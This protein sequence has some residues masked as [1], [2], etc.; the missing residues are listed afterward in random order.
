MR[1]RGLTALLLSTTVF[2]GG[3]AFAQATESS[4]SSDEIVVTAQKRSESIQDVPISIQALPTEKLDELNVASFTDFAALLPSVSFQN[5]T[6]N[7]G[8]NIYIRGV[9]SGGDGNHSGPL[10][11]V[12]VYLDEQP[13]TT[14][15]GP[16]DVNIYDIARI[17]SLAGP[18]GTLYGASS[19]AGT[20]RI[21]TNKPDT[22]SF[23]GRW[24]VE[25][26]QVSEGGTGGKVQGM[27]NI[28][29][30]S[31]AALRIV[32][33]GKHDA[34]F[35]DNVAGTRSFLGG[36][37]VNNARFVED[38]FNAS[39]LYGGR[40]ALKVDLDDNWTATASLIGQQQRSSGISA[41]DESVG[42][43]KVQHFYPDS[44]SDR[45]YQ[46]ALTIEG[47][48]ANFDVT[49][50]GAYLERT[51]H[52]V[53]DYTDYAEAYDRM[54]ASYGGVA[55][56]FY[57]QDALGNTI[58]PRQYII[59]NSDFTKES[60]ELRLAS[61]A[62][63]RLRFVAGAF[64]QKQVHDIF[65]N[66]VVP[67][68]AANLSVNGAPET[69]WLTK[70][71]RVDEDKA[72]FGEATFD[73]TDT[74]SLT[75]GLRAFEYDNSL[76]GFFGFGRD[77]AGP[78]FNAAGSSRT[79][80]AGCYTTTGQVLR[81]NPGGTLLP[82]AI[83]GSPCTNLATFVNGGLVP[84]ATSGD[85]TTYRFNVTYQPTQDLLFYATASSGF[86]PG[87]INRRATIDPYASDELKN[88]EVG[89]KTTWFDRS[90]RWN[91][92]VYEQKW[93][94]FQFAFLG[95]NSF[96]Q[97][98]NGPDAT[99]RGVETDLFWTPLDGLEINASGSYTDA[100]TDNNLC[101]SADP[102]FLCTNDPD[103][104]VSA[105]SGTRLP[106]TP[107]VKLSLSGRYE[108]NVGGLQP[109]AQVLVSYRDSAST[110]LRTAIR[111]SGTLNIINP[112]ALQGRLP[113]ATVVNLAFGTS[114]ND[115]VAELFVS[116]LFDERA[117]LTRYSQCGFCGQ[118]PYAVIETPRTIGVRLG[119]KF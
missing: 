115:M 21:I 26:N 109:Y 83:A 28:P 107:K 75:A 1:G 42:D 66:Y 68:L 71:Q 2:G 45:F 76:I 13:V 47:T 94:S 111:E 57:F 97:I 54:Y 35:I 25:A 86:R 108:W 37:T 69:L 48:L 50:A 62:D 24:D 88:L 106:I 91:G 20:I 104:L 102:T 84:K 72:I 114:W 29:V 93:E 16:I 101:L 43:L 61:P 19:E 32:G 110:D 53:N 39:D 67:G 98:Q 85:G 3:Q 80:V 56:Y 82:A 117:Q 63:W 60:H 81:D 116:N 23:Y 118:R 87:G 89:W 105:P 77:A 10:P 46:A 79:G 51:V 8:T 18:Q 36:V 92:A 34:G 40:A 6:S 65:Q 30:T 64:Y 38:D 33:W 52:T 27:V 4:S 7:G 90:L 100:K 15:A 44:A 96:T 74:I 95:Q 58:D 5:G 31:N 103:N 113:S 73:L 119:S 70:Q 12:G 78:P 55:G 11:S 14:I 112:A 9:A 99:I 17:E 22:G 49:Y 41:F 59:G